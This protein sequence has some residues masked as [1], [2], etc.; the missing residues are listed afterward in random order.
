[1]NQSQGGPYFVAVWRRGGFWNEE[2]FRLF[3]G[4]Q[5]RVQEEMRA[6]AEMGRV[7]H[8]ATGETVW[9]WGGADEVEDLL[10]KRRSV[11]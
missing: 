5:E 11:Q 3:T 10:S 8:L 2:E 6:G 4:A 7:E 1:M 9:V